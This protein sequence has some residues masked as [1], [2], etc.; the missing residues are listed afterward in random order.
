MDRLKQEVNF[1]LS[2]GVLNR[3]RHCHLEGSIYPQTFERIRKEMQAKGHPFP[4]PQLPVYRLP[5]NFEEFFLEFRRAYSLFKY[6][7]TYTIVL[8]EMLKVMAGEGVVYADIHVNLAL[9]RTFNHSPFRIFERLWQTAKPWQDRV[10]CRFM[11]DVP[12]QFA[13]GLFN[14]FIDEPKYFQKHGVTGLSTGG[15]ENMAEPEYF[16]YILE[17]GAALGFEV[18]SHCG[19]LPT[20][21]VVE[22]VL[23]YLPVNRLIHAVGATRSPMLLKKISERNIAVDVCFTSNKQVLGIEYDAHPWRKFAEHG[24][25]IAFGSDDPAI[26]HTTPGKELEL[27]GKLTGLKEE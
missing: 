5:L 1:G 26:F 11:A 27:A 6:P 24:I 17:D 2:N 18:L 14:P 3:D 12:W 22:E 15:D 13:P 16:K 23:R 10:D 25:K 20:N 4:F 21:Y 19:E 7:D 8:D 9:L